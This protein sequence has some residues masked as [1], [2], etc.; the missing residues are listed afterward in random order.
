VIVIV[1]TYCRRLVAGRLR[2]L[3]AS[4]FL[5]ATLL[6]GCE[7]NLP[8][9]PDPK[10]RPVPPDKVLAF[11][12]LYQ[13]NCAGCHGADGKLGPAPPLNDPLFRAIV[14]ISALEKVLNQGRQQDGQ[15]T[16]MPPFAHAG[17]CT[18]SAV[19]I[20]VLVHE[21]KGIRY[22]I[23]RNSEDGKLKI[24]VVADPQG[25][26]PSWGIVDPAPASFPPYAL[27][28]SVGNAEQGAKIFASACASCHGKNGQ[29]IVRKQRLRNKIN[30][31]AFLALISDQ[32]LRRIVI[33]GRPDLGM[34]DYRDPERWNESELL[35]SEEIADLVALLSSWRNG[36]ATAAK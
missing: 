14:P 2:C 35:S 34:P 16:P 13:R 6:A 23:V 1:A 10:N 17:G 5:L 11:D 32:A 3:P 31:P 9:K 24:H 25:I 18:L 21:I 30:D 29:G 28:E 20:Q 27:S 4:L 12:A 36:G 26:V 19:Q 15:K 33:T 7:A 22:G 8:G